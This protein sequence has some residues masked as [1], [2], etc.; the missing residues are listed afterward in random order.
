MWNQ[1]DS[2]NSWLYN[3]ESQN[4][5]NQFDLLYWW[6]KKS[7]LN[8]NQFDLINW[9][10]SNSS[11]REMI[12]FDKLIEKYKSSDDV[13]LKQ[14]I[15]IL[16][17][18]KDSLNNENVSWI[19]DILQKLA[20]SRDFNVING[21]I[22]ELQA[23]S[24][25]YE[26]DRDRNS[27][28][29]KSNSLLLSTDLDV[30]DD[31]MSL[32]RENWNTI[33]EIRWKINEKFWE[34]WN[35]ILDNWWV[36]T[37]EDIN[38]LQAIFET[39][40]DVA[41]LALLDMIWD[42]WIV[43]IWVKIVLKDVTFLLKNWVVLDAE[44]FK[45]LWSNA[46]EE[47]DASSVAILALFVLVHINYW[48][49]AWL[50]FRD[51]VVVMRWEKDS[52]SEKVKKKTK[53]TDADW[54]I[55]HE[56]ELV[57][58][59][60]KSLFWKYYIDVVT[61]QPVIFDMTDNISA[62]ANE[63]IKRK[64]ASDALKLYFYDNPKILNELRVIEEGALQSNTARYW[65]RTWRLIESHGILRTTTSRSI[66]PEYIKWEKEWEVLNFIR[67]KQD[68][69]KT[70]IE[71]FYE[72]K[73]NW[74]VIKENKTDFLKWLYSS[75]ENN[76]DLTKAEK[77]VRISNLESF[78]NKIT[79]E[80]LIDTDRA[81]QELYRITNW[82]LSKIDSLDL[83]QKQIDDIDKIKRWG[84]IWE[85][86]NWSKNKILLKKHH[87]VRLRN[88]IASWNYDWITKD[89]LRTEI[90]RTIDSKVINWWEKKSIEFPTNADFKSKIEA[91][92]SSIEEKL[93]LYKWNSINNL[94]NFIKYILPN[95]DE[96]VIKKIFDA[97]KESKTPYTE[98][99][100]YREIDRIKKGFLPSNQLLEELQVIRQ[101]IVKEIETDSKI[102]KSWLTKQSIQY[103]KS[104]RVEMERTKFDALDVNFWKE[105]D[106]MWKQLDIVIVHIKNWEFINALRSLNN[107]S[108]DLPSGL[109]HKMNNIIDMLN[110]KVRI[111]RI[112][113]ENRIGETKK[114]QEIDNFINEA[115]NKSLDLKPGDIK[116]LKK[117]N[118][119]FDPSWSYI[120]N[121]FNDDNKDSIKAE[122]EKY[123]W[124]ANEDYNQSI[125]LLEDAKKNDIF[126]KLKEQ[127]KTEIELMKVL[128]EAEWVESNVIKELWEFANNLAWDINKSWNE[129]T[130]WQAKPIL[131]SIFN[132]REF[133][134]INIETL[135]NSISDHSEEF[136]W[137]LELKNKIR[138]LFDSIA[139]ES[140]KVKI[141]DFIKDNNIDSRI[142]PQ[143]IKNALELWDVKK[144]IDNIQSF[145][146][147][148]DNMSTEKRLSE[149]EKEYSEYYKDN[150]LNKLDDNFK[151]LNEF[152]KS[153]VDAKY[154]SLN[155]KVIPV[156]ENKQ[157]NNTTD[158]S[159]PKESA[160]KTTPE[161]NENTSL[162]EKIKKYS[163]LYDRALK[164][165]ELD[166]NIDLADELFREKNNWLKDFT[167][168]KT[169]WL[170]S[171]L[172]SR[173]WLKKLLTVSTLNKNLAKIT[174]KIMQDLVNK[175]IV[176]KE[177][178][179]WVVVKE[180]N[181]D[182]K[183]VW[184][185]EDLRLRLEE[186]KHPGLFDYIMKNI[187]T[188]K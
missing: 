133:S 8:G 1:F 129:Y 153:K 100:L 131:E 166:W 139:I 78:L 161:S 43:D 172:K 168:I 73:N 94:E 7:S 32:L 3:T 68:K 51:Y 159:E 183:F 108:Y 88:K 18:I 142:L 150:N 33:V 84:K 148:V 119:G 143:N 185:E 20:N 36:E 167:N 97:F 111:H 164:H 24:D 76:A 13:V 186:L 27:N 25:E 86:L 39:I 162:N 30:I 89:E 106:L 152:F 74:E 79:S 92:Y 163:D 96:N 53:I 160:S 134:N 105:L 126:N 179:L 155:P 175:W 77:K 170:E 75:I 145:I 188:W 140:K 122:L 113:S 29:T 59:K 104:F 93:K 127:Y 144:H 187:K 6:E 46:Y 41:W 48:Y 67:D 64:K 31:T 124:L 91:N 181:W 137:K 62:E 158:N 66:I 63:Y 99:E 82:H 182:Y 173:L 130:K 55:T 149:L 138:N 125:W 28:N 83:V 15:H 156:I 52:K 107:L 38:A 12:T 109:K 118:I 5:D 178:N 37:D 110:N 44:I 50:R 141:L 103:I 54:K 11:A 61:N 87:L 176:V 115:R 4:G 165:A 23:I 184:K 40:W 72:T 65:R 116:E 57:D 10:N 56:E 14:Y 112:K 34:T 45:K 174:D 80:R 98:T 17:Q 90:D 120:S 136:D 117:W 95:E 42:I 157:T 151:D 101:K 180:V 19:N 69:Q 60:M 114:I 58:S 9:N 169:A 35:E 21:Y 47:K 26:S 123:Q 132:R 70:T 102:E 2:L 147:R 177:V 81:M 49:W 171:S 146:D 154:E 128:D 135:S 16:I 71:L 22:K 121:D 85:F